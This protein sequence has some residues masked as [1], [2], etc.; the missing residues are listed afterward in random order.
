ML[1]AAKQTTYRSVSFKI[2]KKKYYEVK[3]ELILASL[4]S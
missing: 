4:K 3:E 1:V 2:Y